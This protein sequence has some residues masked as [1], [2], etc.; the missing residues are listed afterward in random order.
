[1]LHHWKNNFRF[2]EKRNDSRF[3]SQA[4]SFIDLTDKLNIDL[5]WQTFSLPV[6]CLKKSSSVSYQYARFF[7]YHPLLL[8]HINSRI[9]LA[10]GILFWALQ[11][12]SGYIVFHL[13]L[14]HLKERFTDFTAFSKY[15]YRLPNRPILISWSDI[16]SELQYN[17]NISVRSKSTRNTVVDLMLNIASQRDGFTDTLPAW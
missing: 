17:I 4:L 10:L 5:F 15:M 14:G 13:A 6:I 8:S 3:N 1:M 2:D 7:C 12:T 9:S 11:T 16:T